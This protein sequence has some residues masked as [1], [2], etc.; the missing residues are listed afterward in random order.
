MAKGVPKANLTESLTLCNKATKQPRI[1]RASSD[2]GGHRAQSWKLRQYKVCSQSYWVLQNAPK[3]S[4][5]TALGHT[6]TR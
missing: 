5:E 3:K 6:G 1:I 4:S 2:T